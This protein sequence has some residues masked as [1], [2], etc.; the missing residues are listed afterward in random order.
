MGSFAMKTLLQQ[1]LKDERGT[2]SIEIVLVFPV[3]FGFF[4]MTYESGVYSA[5]QVMLEH[6]VDVTVREIRIG[7]ITN[8]D[9]D[10]L[11]ARICSA[12][13]ILPDCI[14]QL[15][16]EL[17]QRDPR[18]AWVDLDAEVRC[19]DR[20]DLDA[21]Y[22]GTID[23]TGNNELMFLRA[24]IRIDPFLPSSAL[25]K[26]FIEANAGDSAAGESYALIATG[27]FVVE[28]FRND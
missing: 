8:P 12:A 26:A 9:R 17:E 7:V 19:V 3:F 28:P 2:A 11:R 10:N 27:A 22:G 14:R 13:R 1:F 25:G 24:C 5:R 21:A 4:L 16:I 6:G 20:G 18:T 23:P 15:E